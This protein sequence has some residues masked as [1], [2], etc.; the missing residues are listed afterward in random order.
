[1]Q[2]RS[3]VS[4]ML[5]R[6]FKPQKCKTSLKLAV[7]RIKLLK[8]K[9]E[10][11][12][13][14]MRRD[15]AQ[16]LETGQEQTARIRVEHVIREQKTMSAYELIEIYC[17]IIDSRL[18]II[19]S[20]KACP[21][22]LKEAIS[23]V[24]FASPRCADIP[25]LMDIR[26]HLTAKYGK[27]F[28]KAALELRPESG[29]SR[30]MVE[31]LSA[32]APDIQTKVNV[33][34]EIAKEHDIKWESKAFEEQVQKPKDD[35][36]S[37][38]S[39]FSSLDKM[40]IKSF[41]EKPSFVHGQNSESTTTVSP[42]NTTSQPQVKSTL[43]EEENVHGSNWKLEFE[44]ATS[45]A[46]AAAESAERASMAARAAAE[47]VRSGNVSSPSFGNAPSAYV[48]KNEGSQSTKS[49]YQ[50]RN[51]T[52]RLETSEDTDRK[53]SEFVK[54]K[55]QDVQKDDLVRT[56]KLTEDE[57]SNNNLDGREKPMSEKTQFIGSAVHPV[58]GNNFHQDDT[59]PH[60]YAQG[61][62]SD[63]RSASKSDADDSDNAEGNDDSVTDYDQGHDTYPFSIHSNIF[64][65]NKTTDYVEDQTEA[66]SFSVH[67]DD[68]DDQS[69]HNE[70][71][72]LDSF[73]PQQRGYPS[74]SL[75]TDSWR[76][77]ESATGFLNNEF[78]SSHSFIE[79][80]QTDYS[81]KIEKADFQED[82]D[83]KLPPKYD[84]PKYD[85]G[86]ENEIEMEKANAGVQ[87]NE[88]RSSHS[89]SEQHQSDHSEN[90]R[91]AGPQSDSDDNLHPKY[92]SPRYDSPSES[93]DEMEKVNLLERR[94]SSNFVDADNS[95]GR[96]PLPAQPSHRTSSMDDGM[97]FDEGNQVSP[98]FH[99]ERNLEVEKGSND[100][101]RRSGLIVHNNQQSQRIDISSHSDDTVRGST[102]EESEDVTAS[103]EGYDSGVLN[104]GRLSGGLRNKGYTG[105]S[106]LQKSN[107]DVLSRTKLNSYDTS[108]NN[109]EEINVSAAVFSADIEEKQSKDL[110][111]NASRIKIRA[112]RANTDTSLGSDGRLAD[113]SSRSVYSEYRT[114]DLGSPVYESNLQQ[115]EGKELSKTF[116]RT[117]ATSPSVDSNTEQIYATG[118]RQSRDSVRT[119]RNQKLNMQ[120]KTPSESEVSEEG[121]DSQKAHVRPYNALSSRKPIS[122][123]N[124][125]DSETD[126]LG[127]QTASVIGDGNAIKFSRR[128]RPAA[129]V[130][131]D[132]APTILNPAR[133]SQAFQL[134]SATGSSFAK[135]K[136]SEDFEGTERSQ[137]RQPYSLTQEAPV[138]HLL[139]EPSTISESMKLSQDK[140]RQSSVK[141][142][143]EKST[144][145]NSYSKATSR[146]PSAKH[147]PTE[148]SAVRESSRLSQDK[149]RHPP[150]EENNEKST[151]TNSSST[152]ISRENSSKNSSHVHPNLPD[153][154][155]IA[156]HFQSLR[157]NV[158]K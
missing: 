134:K 51:Y 6:S 109:N 93:E 83:G 86:S 61:S 30:M 94:G 27:D 106:H 41:N 55:T 39:S 101:D 59:K 130:K 118:A 154:D 158:R 28:A 34:T 29:V 19:E 119:F 14:Q 57:T 145:T 26:K 17:E 37:G 123:S 79:Q 80:Q 31:K 48:M 139:T 128:T 58:S 81:E 120:I 66:H 77:K 156:A 157:A 40:E 72:L 16:L 63:S 44:D 46:E 7:S 23:S 70:R 92:D 54:P 35:L 103:N 3:R 124:F 110:H 22:D 8:N 152:S 10:V 108:L 69:R 121:L 2:S 56:N 36:L 33:M 116:L 99:N 85:S 62:L 95:A 151:A 49:K 155:S 102:E 71:N 5:T 4:E 153:Y 25:E 89:F 78:I 146:E 126:N 141:E 104:F 149:S 96:G 140:S 136:H 88:I 144:T 65:E 87:N 98:S 113:G 82:S 135:I 12:V 76:N 129:Q 127:S 132:K 73:L 148:P 42:Y 67:F 150:V 53:G 11:L 60:H 114:E 115:Q 68:Y 18:P 97:I 13:K 24:I 90:I 117:S 75:N 91:K 137:H 107:A 50:D 133:D 105:P 45:A 38:P 9:R 142:K 32:N 52:S 84:S 131:E 143:N 64:K 147:L 43:A 1:M 112:S 138:K 20:Q 15:L 74:P 125:D 21:I 111:T 122:N 47:L 100:K